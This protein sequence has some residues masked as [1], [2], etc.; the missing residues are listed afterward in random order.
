[1]F[2]KFYISAFEQIN[3]TLDFCNII[4]IKIQYRNIHMKDYYY[5]IHTY[6]MSDFG[7]SN[8]AGNGVYIN[9]VFQLTLLYIHV[10]LII[11]IN[12]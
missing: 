5:H 4:I 2:W 12:I 6:Y 9:I 3:V 8:M 10:T 7:K 1:M 11:K